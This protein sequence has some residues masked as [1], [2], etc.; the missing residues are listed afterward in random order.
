[1]L[2]RTKYLEMKAMGV[3]IYGLTSETSYSVPPTIAN[4]IQSVRSSATIVISFPPN[5][6][7]QRMTTSL[8]FRVCR[9]MGMGPYWQTMFMIPDALNGDLIAFNTNYQLP[10]CNDCKSQT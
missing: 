4:A 8:E 5:S 1:M 7:T 10:T 3:T 9:E 6:R 2:S